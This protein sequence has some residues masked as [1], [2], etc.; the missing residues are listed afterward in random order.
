MHTFRGGIHPMHREHYGKES[1]RE[2]AVRSFRPERVVIPMGMHLGAPSEPC[3]KEG[4][5][6]KIGQVIANTVGGL[7]LPVHASVSGVVTAVG[8]HICSAAQ[9]MACVSIQNDHK[10]ERTDCRPLGAVETVDPSRII[11]QIK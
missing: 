4:D 9:P 6:V 10:D 1:T 3:V 5:R 7:G 2:V 8:P 11:P